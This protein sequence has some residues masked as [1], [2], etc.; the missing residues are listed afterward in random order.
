MFAKIDSILST[1]NGLM[2]LAMT[3]FATSVY[4]TEAPVG[5]ELAISTIF[6]KM[7]GIQLITLAGISCLAGSGTYKTLAVGKIM[8]IAYMAYSM[9]GPGKA[10]WEDAKVDMTPGY[11]WLVVY[12]LQ[13][14]WYATHDSSG[15]KSD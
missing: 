12:V 13:A 3:D 15:T 2:L 11:F 1:V 5:R 14:F 8:L 7:L 9:F 6:F 10:V 4:Y